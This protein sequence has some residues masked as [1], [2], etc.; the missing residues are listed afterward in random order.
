[1]PTAQAAD[2]SRGGQHGLEI[3][4]AVTEELFMEQEP[5]GTRIT[6]RIALSDTP[7]Q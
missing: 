4:K 3:V 2:A 6:A 5:V 1:M 7:Q